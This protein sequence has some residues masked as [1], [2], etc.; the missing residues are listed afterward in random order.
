[1]DRTIADFLAGMQLGVAQTHKNMTLHCLIGATECPITYLTLDEALKAEALRVQELSEGGSVPELRVHNRAERHVLLLDGEELVGAKQNRVLNV[2]I[3]IAAGSET[4]IPVSCVEQGRWSYRSRQFSSESRVMSSRLRKSKSDSVCAS[5]RHSGTYASDQ[6]M[7]WS[8]IRAKHARM[9]SAPSP[10]MAMA[11]LYDT[12]VDDVREFMESFRPVQGQAGMI[13]FI[14]DRPA[15]MEL[16]GTHETLRRTHAKLVQS[17]VMDA[18]ETSRGWGER[19]QQSHSDE[20]ADYLRA[21]AQ[22]DVERR[23]SVGLGQDLRIRSAGLVG[24]GL[25]FEGYVLHLSVFPNDLGHERQ[26][27]SG[28]LTRA[29]RRRE[30]LRG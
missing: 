5:L 20:A 30:L 6:A 10:T 17:Y 19:R 23:V 27:G 7:V 13:V 4:V 12:H 16:F 14:D 28:P 3:L 22:T 25:E 26:E 21:A 2:T 18:L 29:S 8:D 11:D 24:A 1:M 15:G 9:E